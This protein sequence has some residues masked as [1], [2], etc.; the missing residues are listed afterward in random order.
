MQLEKRSK[1]SLPRLI[2]FV[3]QSCQFCSDDH[4]K[5]NLLSNEEGGGI[6]SPPANGDDNDD[7]D[8]HHHHHDGDDDDDDDDDEDRPSDKLCLCMVFTNCSL[9]FYR[10]HS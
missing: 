8:H 10:N 7:D 4:L 3:P 5:R 2:S 1:P 9:S 6:P